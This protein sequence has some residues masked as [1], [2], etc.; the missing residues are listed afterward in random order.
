MSLWTQAALN[1]ASG[2][3]PTT[4]NGWFGRR[5]GNDWGCNNHG[6]IC[7]NGQSCALS[8]M[9]LSAL[10]LMARSG[11]RGSRCWK[12][13]QFR[14]R[15]CNHN[16][17]NALRGYVGIPSDGSGTTTPDIHTFCGLGICNHARNICCAG[18][19]NIAIGAVFI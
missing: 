18:I 11:S 2:F 19:G 13:N 6:H 7:A 14:V 8:L 3:A 15:G 17:G 1:A 10:L 12:T 9:L 4:L 5:R 16:A